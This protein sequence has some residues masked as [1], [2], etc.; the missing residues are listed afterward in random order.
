MAVL[1]YTYKCGKK[2]PLSITYLQHNNLL[3]RIFYLQLLEYIVY[4][5]SYHVTYY[6]FYFITFTTKKICLFNWHNKLLHVINCY[7]FLSFFFNH[8]KCDAL[9]YKISCYIWL[10][11]INFFVVTRHTPLKNKYIFS[12]YTTS[13]QNND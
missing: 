1:R 9:T 12:Y 5:L 13:N 6:I 11:V 7:H 10:I 2:K 4:L 3:Y 8:I